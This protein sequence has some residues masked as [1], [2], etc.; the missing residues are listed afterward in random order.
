M[1]GPYSRLDITVHDSWRIVVRAA[2]LKLDVGCRRDLTLRAARK[3]FY[4]SMLAEHGR[5]QKLVAHFK[6]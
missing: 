4:R 3:R 6:L 2:A 5:A 1:S